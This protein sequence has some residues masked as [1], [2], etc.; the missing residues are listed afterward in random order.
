MGL[1]VG[2][3]LGSIGTKNV[4][5]HHSP[6]PSPCLDY[7]LNYMNVSEKGDLC[8]GDDSIVKYGKSPPK[9]VCALFALSSL[10]T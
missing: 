1:V 8:F 3:Y 10:P 7:I 6:F 5:E 9:S 2:N 4:Q